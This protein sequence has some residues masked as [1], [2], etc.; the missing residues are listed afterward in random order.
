MTR[1]GSAISATPGW[2]ATRGPR[3]APWA[4]IQA[5]TG[6][7]EAS[8]LAAA[9]I[10]ACVLRL[11]YCDFDRFEFDAA[12]SEEGFEARGFDLA[13]GRRVLPGY[14]LEREDTRRCS[15][16]R[17]QVIEEMLGD[18]L[19]VVYAPHAGVCRLITAWP[20]AGFEL[21]LWHEQFTR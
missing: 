10:P 3:R 19:V 13:Y 21:E 9:A 16:R 18:V 5:P 15:E 7:A 12:K 1:V 11:L 6:T 14:V 2:A 4:P 17:F 20:A 8:D